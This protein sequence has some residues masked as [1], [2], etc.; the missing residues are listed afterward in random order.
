MS[1]QFLENKQNYHMTQQFHSQVCIKKTEILCS[2]KN[3]YKNIHI[4]IHN[5]Q[6]VEATQAS[7]I[8]WTINKM[9]YIQQWNIIQPYY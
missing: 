9:W 3:L 8:R 5:R 4:I 7:I 2:C 6:K 1:E